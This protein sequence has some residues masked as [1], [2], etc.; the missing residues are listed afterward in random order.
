MT[1]R[2]P[3]AMPWL[4]VSMQ[5]CFGVSC[6]TMWLCCAHIEKIK[7]YLFLQCLA[8]LTAL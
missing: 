3:S 6:G 4:C 8:A 2:E 5:V 1:I 7:A